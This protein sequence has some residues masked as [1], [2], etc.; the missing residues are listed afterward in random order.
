MRTHNNIGSDMDMFPISHQ[1]IIY[2]NAGSF[3]TEPLGTIFGGNSS[4][5]YWY[6]FY[7]NAD[8]IQDTAMYDISLWPDDTGS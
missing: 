1:A 8:N 4:I 6:A 7:Q 5:C 3:L 2:P